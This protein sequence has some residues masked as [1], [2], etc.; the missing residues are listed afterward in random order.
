MEI[1]YQ[2]APDVHVLPNSQALPGLGVLPVNAY[3]LLAEEPVLVDAGIGPDGDEF[4]DALSSI[5][6]PRTLRWIWLTHDDADHTGSLRR[7]LDM[8]P[9]A[10]LVTHA[11]CALRMS[12]WW[13]VPLERVHAIRVGDRLPVGDRTLRAVAPPLYDNP[14]STGLLDEATGALFS[15]DSFGAILPE[16]SQDAA[17]V[18]QDA[19]AGGMRA[20]AA[21]DSPWT[22]VVDRQQFGQVLDG[23]RRLQPTRIFSSHL[24]AAS[25]T[26]LERFLDVLESVPDA[27]PAVAPSHQEFAHMLAALTA[28]PGEPQPV[29]AM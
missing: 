1:P 24:P 27:E 11:F 28:A 17:E 23:V 12:S 22:H 26:S 4:V 9:S 20:W 25:G 10:R 19:L 18:P 21:A 6:D 7:V 29:A 14:M 8:A 3:V 15:V 2:A 16:P 13:P 5:L